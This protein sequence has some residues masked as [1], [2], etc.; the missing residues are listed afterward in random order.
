[1]SRRLAVLA[2]LLLAACAAPPPASL[3]ALSGDPLE[4]AAALLARAETARGADQ[5]A[6]LIARLDALGVA[7]VAGAADD[8]LARWRAEHVPGAGE[9]WRGRTLGPGYRRALVPAGGE[10]VIEQIFTAGERAE[11]AAEVR[12]GNPVALAIANPREQ[13]VC[14]V[15]L[16]PNARCRW[17]PV[18]T[19]RYAIRLENRGRQPASVWLVFR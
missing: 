11:M 16:A 1:M 15:E 4:D 7:A 8:P 19:E 10:L 6:P 3:P 9:V 17:L 5:R 18:F 2:P 12:G 13:R 14:E